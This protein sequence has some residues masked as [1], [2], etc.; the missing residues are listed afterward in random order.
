MPLLLRA[1]QADPQSARTF[2]LMARVTLLKRWEEALKNAEQAA[3]WAP[4]DEWSHRLRSIIYGRKGKTAKAYACAREAVRLEPDSLLALS[5][6]FDA[7]ISPAKNIK[8]R[9]KP[10]SAPGRWR[11]IP[12]WRIPWRA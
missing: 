8:T 2:N 9:E 3:H 1:A 4:N 6:L 10:P 11:R 5:C 12:P 7:Q